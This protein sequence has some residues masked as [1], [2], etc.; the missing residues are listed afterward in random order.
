MHTQRTGDR[1]HIISRAWLK[2]FLALRTQA[3]IGGQEGRQGWGLREISNEKGNQ[4]FRIARRTRTGSDLEAAQ[5]YGSA[6]EIISDVVC[7]DLNQPR[8]AVAPW[9]LA[10]LA[11]IVVEGDHG[12]GLSCC[13]A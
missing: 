9:S 5:M 2:A 7:T 6:S 8:A 10:K 1:L 11:T 4:L 13:M 3:T 12:E